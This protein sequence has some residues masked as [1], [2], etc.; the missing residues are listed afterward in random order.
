MQLTLL[1][2]ADAT[3]DSL[4]CYC[5]RKLRLLMETAVQMVDAMTEDS[6]CLPLPKQLPV[7]LL[8]A[9]EKTWHCCKWCCYYCCRKLKLLL[10]KAVAVTTK[11]SC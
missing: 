1:H 4:C 10:Q 9:A 6:H 2:V 5:S 3:A 7:Q 11:G 8:H